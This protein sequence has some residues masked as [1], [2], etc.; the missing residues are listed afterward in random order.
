MIQSIELAIDGLH[1][2]GE[3]TTENVR[4]AVREIISFYQEKK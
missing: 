3:A 4:D 2:R 1:R